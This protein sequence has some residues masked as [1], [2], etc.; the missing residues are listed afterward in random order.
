MY[1][2]KDFIP[3][4][5]DMKRLIGLFGDETEFDEN[6]AKALDDKIYAEIYDYLN[7][8]IEYNTE[9][10]MNP[11]FGSESGQNEHFYLEPVISVGQEQIL[12]NC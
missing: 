1:E 8:H 2:I 4:K 6:L 12:Q 5:N 9:P 10:P 7:N 3:S 11:N